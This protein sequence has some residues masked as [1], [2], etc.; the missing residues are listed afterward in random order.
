[1]RKLVEFNVLS[2]EFQENPYPT[3]AKLHQEKEILIDRRLNAYFVGHYD[4]VKQVLNSSEFT[5]APLSKRAE[6]VMG[7]RVLAQ[8][9]GEEHRIKRRAVLSRLTGQLFQE[10]YAPL[11]TQT[12]ECLLEKY[13]SSGK[14]DLIKNFG[15]DYSVLVTLQVLG[16]PTD[17]YREIA[18][19]HNGI[20]Q[21]ITSLSMSEEQIDFSLD[22]SRR[23]IEYLTPIVDKCR[24]NPDDGFISSLC[25]ISPGE[26]Q[27]TTP[28]VVALVLNVLLA[29]TEPAD[30]TL[31]YL[32]MHLLQNPDQF[33]LV[34]QDR[35]LLS[36]AIDESLRITSPVQLIPRQAL[37]DSNVSGVDIPGGAMVFC[38]IGAANRDPSVFDRPGDF[39]IRRRNYPGQPP[40][41]RKAHHMAFGVGMHVCVGAAFSMRQIELTANIILERLSNLK[42]APNQKLQEEGI[43]TRGLSSLCLEFD[44][45]DYDFMSFSN[46]VN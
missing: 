34:M 38:M 29:A 46:S 18:V 2:G 27:M 9:H 11:I 4:G 32:F 10:R 28:E 45:I 6:P 26:Q 25:S 12:T 16:L 36:S 5:T 39:L 19:W 31:A 17:R 33:Q 24:N 37:N 13:I 23:L 42:L 8:M 14:I 35:S 3:Y 7:D 44:P 41:G 1:M 20:T 15:K 43:Y 40:L 22:C 21:F 30:K